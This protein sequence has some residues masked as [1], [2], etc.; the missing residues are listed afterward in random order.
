M[1]IPSRYGRPPR[2]ALTSTYALLFE[3]R[4]LY[5][6]FYPGFFDEVQE[7]LKRFHIDSSGHNIKRDRPVSEVAISKIG[8][9]GRFPRLQETPGREEIRRLRAT[10]R[11]REP[12]PQGIRVELEGHEFSRLRELLRRYMNLRRHV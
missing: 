7:T 5:P 3:I 8:L 4:T 6:S 10:R 9:S 12:A 1:E 11:F 2:L